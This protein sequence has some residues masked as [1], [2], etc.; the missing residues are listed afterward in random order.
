M[1][2]AVHTPARAEP[3]EAGEAEAGSVEAAQHVACA[4]EV[5]EEERHALGSRPLQGDEPLADMLERRT[6]APAEQIDVIGE[7]PPQPRG[8]ARRA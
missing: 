5:D 4:V 2:G 1:K 6:E 3:A 7:R 8:S